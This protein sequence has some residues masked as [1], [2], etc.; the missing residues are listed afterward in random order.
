MVKC[1]LLDQYLRRKFAFLLRNVS[2]LRL[3]SAKVTEIVASEG[4]AFQVCTT[5]WLKKCL[6]TSRVLLVLP[7][8]LSLNTCPLVLMAADE[9][10]VRG[11]GSLHSVITTTATQTRTNAAPHSPTRDPSAYII[12]SLPS[13]QL[14]QLPSCVPVLVQLKCD[15]LRTLHACPSQPH[16]QFAFILSRHAN[17]QNKYT[18]H[19]KG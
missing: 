13:P 3:N 15:S 12:A 17:C 16:T 7:V 5:L 14:C 8:F 11:Y 4:S 2:S 18:V 19:Q 10:A 6:L 9:E 1:I